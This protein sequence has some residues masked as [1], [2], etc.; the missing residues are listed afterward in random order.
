MSIA[1]SPIGSAIAG[2]QGIQSRIHTVV[3]GAILALSA[4]AMVFAAPVM[5]TTQAVASGAATVSVNKN[6]KARAGACASGEATVLIDVV[7]R[8][9]MIGSGR[10]VAGGGAAITVLN[11]IDGLVLAR[12]SGTAAVAKNHAFDGRTGA[13]A[14]GAASR[15]NDL[16]VLVS[17]VA[18]ASGEADH[19]V[20]VSPR[21]RAGAVA[22][23]AAGQ[24]QSNLIYGAGGALTGGTSPMSR[25]VALTQTAQAVFGS[26]VTSFAMRPYFAAMQV[27]AGARQTS[28]DHTS[29]R[30]LPAP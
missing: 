19:A 28:Q 9:S 20:N 29:C 12:A 14:S 17:G 1:S 30:A 26:S 27:S 21:G 3:G 22:N 7:G 11:N 6:I 23:G 4:T 24:L 2:S 25:H 8:G 16:V 5:A 15:T 13:V 10:G 18:V